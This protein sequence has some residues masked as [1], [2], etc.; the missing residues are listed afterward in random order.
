M[1]LMFLHLFCESEPVNLCPYQVPPPRVFIA[2]GDS[3][4][5]GMG[6]VGYCHAPEGVHTQILYDRL[7]HSGYVDH[8]IN[9]AVSG[10]TTSSLLHQLNQL[11]ADILEYFQNARVITINIG[12][13]NI[14]TPF[15]GHLHDL[16]V[17]DGAENIR[18]GAGG[19][20]SGFWG[21]ISEI[22]GG[23]GGIVT[24]GDTD[25]DVANVIGG[26]GDMVS[27]LVNFFDGAYDLL[28][29]TPDVFNTWMGTL[30]PPLV[31]SLED[32]VRTFDYDFESILVWLETNAPDATLIISTIYNP[33]PPEVA[34]FSVPLYTWAHVLLASM[35]STIVATGEARGHL[36]VDLYSYMSSRLDILLFN[37]N[38]FYGEISFDFVHPNLEGHEL[39]AQKQYAAFRH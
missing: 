36:V 30:P 37:L 7:Y 20:A 27:G 10:R 1:V 34:F 26:F 6:L 25:F 23:I 33:I 35:N 28:A 17:V 32:G 5:S 12:G 39:I 15:L 21:A 38:P 8:Y 24:G 18:T 11:D 19:V 2:L 22:A 14:L 13:N 3:V 29:G 31:E 16:Q 4:S 9:I